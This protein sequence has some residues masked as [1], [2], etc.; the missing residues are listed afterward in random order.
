M[1][2]SSMQQMMTKNSFENQPQAM[3]K[4]RGL[5]GYYAKMLSPTNVYMI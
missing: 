3:K 4:K 1:Q 2:V 5:N